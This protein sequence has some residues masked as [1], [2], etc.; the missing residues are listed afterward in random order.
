MSLY[1]FSGITF[2]SLLLLVAC[3]GSSGDGSSD[4]K[5]GGVK[6]SSYLFY[7][8]SLKAVDSES[9]L[10]PIV[11]EAG[12][13]IINGS[14]RVVEMA[15]Y[16]A[17]TQT[18]RNEHSHALIYAKRDGRLYKVNALKDRSLTP[19]QISSEDVA[20]QICIPLSQRY[21]IT[22]FNNPDNSQ[23]L[24][25]LPGV[26]ATCDTADDLLKMVRLGM[27]SND[28]PMTA[29]KALRPL[30]DLNSGAINGW[31]VN[32]AGALKTCD[33]NFRNCGSTIADVA[34][35]AK[36]WLDSRRH[37]WLLLGMD[38]QFFIYD[39]LTQTLSPPRFTV[40]AGSALSGL[41]MADENMVY[42][43]Y[44][45]TIYQFPADGS[46]DASVLLAETVAITLIDVAT[47]KLLY[48]QGD[49]IKAIEKTGGT[50][51]TLVAGDNNLFV[52]TEDDLVYYSYFLLLWQ[53]DPGS[54][55][56]SVLINQF[57]KAGIVTVGGD[58]LFERDNAQW[59]FQPGG[60]R[61]VWLADEF[62]HFYG[63]PSTM[64]LASSGSHAS[65]YSLPGATLQAFNTSTAEA[66]AMLGV[67]P[68][69][70]GITFLFCKQGTDG[71]LCSTSHQ[72]TTEEPSS[73]TLYEGDV[74]FLK[75]D[76]SDSFLRVTNTP[77]KTESVVF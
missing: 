25:A 22:D 7:Q 24:Y 72:M 66:G 27:S 50:A 41:P 53:P 73:V 62:N 26:D 64:I 19:V 35:D 30:M 11:V 58:V 5:I 75:T 63:E 55:N 65:G 69:D 74:Y 31:L 20:N 46:A 10:S 57:N 32:D 68:D 28:D 45:N 52:H 16:N 37:E 21:A 6:A 14:I 9:P 18:S 29:K 48:R 76:E 71:M 3:G 13:D 39:T 40:A 38:D 4:I 8:G 54:G 49:S 44:N 70:D 36:F 51:M 67:L 34:T 60:L 12:E 42:F 61:P 77:E 43:A 1:Y 17:V 47:N 23:Y 2:L 33:A 15:D 59:V 56:G